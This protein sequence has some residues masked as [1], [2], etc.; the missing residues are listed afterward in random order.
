MP[1]IKT[2][3]LLLLCGIFLFAATPRCQ[4]Q[5]TGALLDVKAPP[6]VVS[7]TFVPEVTAKPTSEPLQE[8]SAREVSDT[9]WYWRFL[10]MITLGFAKYNTDKQSDGRPQPVGSSR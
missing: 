8:K 2:K 10:G 7:P 4:A 3:I 6:A 9:P 5:D 1:E